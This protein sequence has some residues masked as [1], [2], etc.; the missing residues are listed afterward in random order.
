LVALDH[1]HNF[2]KVL[3]LLLLLLLLSTNQNLHTGAGGAAV[4]TLRHPQL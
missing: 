3:L 4:D 2:S 1:P